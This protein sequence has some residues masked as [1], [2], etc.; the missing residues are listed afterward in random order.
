MLQF[1]MDKGAKLDS[2]GGGGST[3]LLHACWEDHADCALA[4]INAGANVNLASNWNQ[5][6]LMYAAKHGDDPVVVALIAHHAEVNAKCKEG[7]PVS[8]AADSD[9]LSTLKLLC[10]AGAYVSLLPISGGSKLY[11]VLGMM[12]AYNDLA[13]MDYSLS[14]NVNVDD[15]GVS[16][17]TPLI[18]AASHASSQAVKVLI[19]K[20]AKV[21]VQ[22]SF[23]YTALMWVKDADTAL[24]LLQHGANK[25]LKDK[26]HGMTALMLA[27]CS[28][29]REKARCLIDNGA[30][31]NAMDTQGETA[32]TIAGDV[33]N[34]EMVQFLKDKGATRTEIHIIEKGVGNYDQLLPPAR[35]WALAV[36]AIYAQRDGLDPKVL[37]RGQTPERAKEGL[38]ESWNIADKASLLNALDNLCDSGGGSP[39]AWNLCRAAMLANR[40]FAANYIEDTEAWNRLM[41]IARQTQTSFSSWQEVSDSFLEGRTAWANQRDPHFE[42]CAQLLLNPKDPNSVWNQC[43]WKTDLSSPPAAK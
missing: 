28:E 32:L 29:N 35:Y 41:A 27:S 7:P 13:G 12:A 19:E 33:G 8:W 30:N 4:L 25:E 20:G 17:A 1:L 37:G 6:P 23:G 11:S 10:A 3:A 39:S 38:K 14:Q 40:G 42:A 36:G 16:G 24:V 9:H 5:C 43:P 34:T 18:A 2:Q 15:P 26:E 21:D 22:D 31:I